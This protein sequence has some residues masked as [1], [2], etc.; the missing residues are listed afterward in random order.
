MLGNYIERGNPKCDEY[1]P[2]EDSEGLTVGNF[3]ISFIESRIIFGSVQ[4]KGFIL[5]NIETGDV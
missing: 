1:L 4:Q 5:K 3:E 2:C